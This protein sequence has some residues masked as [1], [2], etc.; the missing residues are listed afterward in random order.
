MGRDLVTC[1][2]SGGIGNILFQVANGL[3]YASRYNKRFFLSQ[4]D[5][6]STHTG[7]D[8]Y[9]S[10]I[11]SKID[12]EQIRPDSFFD[13]GVSRYT[14]ANFCYSDIP[15]IK[16]GV[17]LEGYFQSLRYFADCDELI[18]S[19]LVLDRIERDCCSIH[20][21]RGDYLSLQDKHTVLPVDYYN[22][23]ISIV[24]SD[25]YIVFSDDTDWCKT[26]FIGDRFSF[27]EGDPYQSL[28]TMASCR[29]HIIA[30]SSFSWWGSYF[31]WNK[32]KKVVAPK[33]WFGPS[34]SNNNTKDLYTENMIVI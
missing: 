18:R 17:I 4:L 14:E 31:G 2:T 16:G 13:G 28:A 27:F 5:Y 21:R 25:K 24:P 30:N 32:N 6:G 11:L 9:R 34:Y 22:K 23:A 7:I 19:E 20:V 29:D 10:N 8:F 1:I 3:A 33:D 26:V 12:Y 15:Y